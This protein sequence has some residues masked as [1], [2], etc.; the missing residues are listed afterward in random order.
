MGQGEG[1][2]EGGGEGMAI[3]NFSRVAGKEEDTGI[4]GSGHSE[5]ESL[6][7]GDWALKE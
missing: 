7:E 5:G 6:C 1:R 2:G 4:R 3:L